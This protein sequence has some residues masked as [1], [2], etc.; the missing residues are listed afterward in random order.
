MAG[1]LT[2]FAD[3]LQSRS[4]LQREESA[5]LVGEGEVVMNLTA[6]SLED[7][8]LGRA[9]IMHCTA[10]DVMRLLLSSGS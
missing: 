8:F 10:R 4:P 7:G 6:Q 3:P 5:F 2:P 9:Y 1:P